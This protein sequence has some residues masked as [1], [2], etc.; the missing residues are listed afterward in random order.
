MHFQRMDKVGSPVYNR[1]ADEDGFGF[2]AYPSGAHAAR[3]PGKVALMTSSPLDHFS[4]IR[5]VSTC[6]LHRTRLRQKMEYSRRLA[7]QGTC[8]Q[9][10]S[11]TDSRPAIEKTVIVRFFTSSLSP[12]SPT[13]E[14]DTGIVLV[15]RQQE[16]EP[17]GIKIFDVLFGMIRKRTSS[18][19]H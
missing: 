8:W 5:L 15:Y 19:S 9:P 13:K 12:P 4:L 7:R 18:N 10:D 3:R 2:P 1:R 17:P 16:P 6:F 11:N 14:S